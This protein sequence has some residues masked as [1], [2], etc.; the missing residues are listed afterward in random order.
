MLSCGNFVHF[1]PSR[2]GTTMKNL[3]FLASVLV[4]GLGLAACGD[5]T[6]VAPS[7]PRYDSGP[8]FGT[9]HRAD[10][11]SVITS[12]SESPAL[13]GPTFGTGH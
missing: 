7:S 10:S 11:T 4:L 3:R 9:G 2:E 5:T 8:T 12:S 6:L 13:S 1:P